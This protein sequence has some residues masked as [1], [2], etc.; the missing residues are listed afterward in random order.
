MSLN[1]CKTFVMLSAS[2]LIVAASVTSSD[3]RT[4]GKRLTQSGSVYYHSDNTVR[5]GDNSCLR[6]TGLPAM[7]ACSA[8]GG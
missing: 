6:S 7:Y 1:L 5:D 4:H 2:M 3:A 8:N